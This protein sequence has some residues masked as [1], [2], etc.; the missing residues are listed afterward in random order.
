MLL[1]MPPSAE[2]PPSSARRRTSTVVCL[3]E[4]NRGN[5][6]N[7][8]RWV[9][10]CTFA[11]VVAA[12]ACIA[13][14]GS[15]PERV[16][17]APAPL[18]LSETWANGGTILNDAPCGVGRVLARGVQRR[19]DDRGRGRRPPGRP[20]R[21]QPADRRRAPGLGH[22]LGQHRRLGPGL[23]DQPVRA[24][25][26]RPA[27]TASRS[28]EARPST[29]PPRSTAATG[30]PSVPATRPNRSTAGTTPTTRTGPRPGTRSSPTRP[31]TPPP[32]A[33]SRRRSRSPTGDRWWKAA[34]WVR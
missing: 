24:D 9:A 5:V 29:R 21:T 2:G 17:G 7:A 22:R 3:A 13:I 20:L 25:H 11:G 33:A 14:V 26:R 16:S 32:T 23:P 1:A 8:R 10:R 12:G 6:K 15:T 4:Q 19:R 18:T 28:R 30:S 27:S 31:P 34:R